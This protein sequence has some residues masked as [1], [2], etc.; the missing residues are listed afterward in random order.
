M[1]EEDLLTIIKIRIILKAFW[2]YMLYSQVIL[3][4]KSILVTLFKDVFQKAMDEGAA[5]KL[6]L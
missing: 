1:F 5:K 4:C 2:K 6:T 3:K